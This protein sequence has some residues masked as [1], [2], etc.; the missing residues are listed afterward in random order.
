[1]KKFFTVFIILL[2]LL[3]AAY[4]GARVY[5]PKIL[6]RTITSEAE[7][8]IIPPRIQDKMDVIK[9]EVSDRMEELPT[10]LKTSELDYDDL[11]DLIKKVETDQIVDAY[12]ALKSQAWES[13]DD[14]FDIGLQSIEVEGYNLEQFRSFFNEHTT[15]DQIRE[16]MEMLEENEDLMELYI[17]IAK[18]TARELLKK[19]REAILEKME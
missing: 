12:E 16:W 14:A 17:P 13:T 18:E 2:I 15:K 6:A 11:A 9:T 1:M 5:L 7:S 8:K 19:N 4:W 3:G 10:V